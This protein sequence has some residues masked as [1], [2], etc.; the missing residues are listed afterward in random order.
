MLITVYV[1]LYSLNQ[2][3]YGYNNKIIPVWGFCG[4]YRQRNCSI[5]NYCHQERA[6]CHT[7]I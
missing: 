2:T 4:T 3:A 7:S 1:K 6:L 5:R